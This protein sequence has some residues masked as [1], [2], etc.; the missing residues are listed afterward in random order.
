MTKPNIR[1]YNI[2]IRL[3]VALLLIVGLALIWQV[4]PLS[5]YTAPEKVLPLLEGVHNTPWILPVTLGL[6]VLGTLIFFPHMIMTAAIVIIFAP[7]E[8]LCI[9]ML[10]SLISG[11]IG[12]AAGRSLGA[13][14]LHTMIGESSIKISAYAKKGGVVGITLLRMVPIA[15]YTV[16][17]LALGMMEITFLTFVI[18]TFLGMLPGTLVSV[19]LGH[20]IMELWQHPDVVG[21]IAVGF[22]LATWLGIIVLMHF[23]VRRWQKHSSG[24]AQI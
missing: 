6:Y 20:Y 5:E 17:N 8:A 2:P 13:Q 3:I 7:L 16:V 24:A 21:L 15:P 9:A 12:Y 22:G 14:S 18:A 23:L 4:T 10:G 19:F 1:K 11:I